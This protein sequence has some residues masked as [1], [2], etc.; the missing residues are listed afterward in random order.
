[1]LFTIFTC[2][3]ST[4]TLTYIYTYYEDYEEIQHISRIAN[5]AEPLNQTDGTEDNTFD[6]CVGVVNYCGQDQDLTE[7]KALLVSFFQAFGGD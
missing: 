1:M 7:Q 6:V 2:R 5:Y 4:H 3:P